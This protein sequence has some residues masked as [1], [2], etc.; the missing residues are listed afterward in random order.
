MAKSTY[1]RNALINAALRATNFTAP[2]TVYVA[3]HS[4]AP[5]A[6]GSA[7]ELSG[8]GYARTAA[9]FVSPTAGATSNSAEVAFPAATGSDWA[10]ASYFSIWDAASAGN[11]LH[12][13][14]AAFTVPK[15]VQVGDNA[16]FA[17]G[18]LTVNET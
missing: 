5:G 16:R 14:D 2:A 17:I 3:L 8:N 7:N 12:L 18:A 9:T 4:G 15:T 10:S 6:T 1:L 11:C 13:A